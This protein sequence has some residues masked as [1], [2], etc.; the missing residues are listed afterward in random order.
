MV[1]RTKSNP[2]LIGYRPP[3]RL[4]YLSSR[5]AIYRVRHSTIHV[6]NSLDMQ[7][8]VEVE[9]LHISHGKLFQRYFCFNIHSPLTFRCRLLLEKGLTTKCNNET[10]LTTSC[11]LPKNIFVTSFES[12]TTFENDFTQTYPNLES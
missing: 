6:R 12:F 3:I 9:T 4:K 11:K 5:K 2:Q 8:L 10:T 7:Y 1:L